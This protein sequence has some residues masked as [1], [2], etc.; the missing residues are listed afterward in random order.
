MVV[1]VDTPPFLL[2]LI[3]QS[4]SLSFASLDDKE[5]WFVGAAVGLA[6]R[7]LRSSLLRRAHCLKVMGPGAGVS[8]DIT[9]TIITVPVLNKTSAS[10]YGYEKSKFTAWLFEQG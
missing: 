6:G 3:L 9:S 1:E 5:L 7:F 8:I 2:R 4:C 10:L